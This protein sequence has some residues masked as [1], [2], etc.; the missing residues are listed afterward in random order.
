MYNT[1]STLDQ[2]VQMYKDKMYYRASSIEIQ[3]RT[4]NDQHVYMHASQVDA[5]TVY[6]AYILAEYRARVYGE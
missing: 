4:R 1:K 3:T 2:A 5:A 6:A